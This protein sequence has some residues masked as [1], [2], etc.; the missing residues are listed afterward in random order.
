MQAKAVVNALVQNASE[1]SVTLQNQDVFYTAV[2]GGNRGGKARRA[3]S[4]DNQ[5]IFH[6]VRYSFL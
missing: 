6:H 3:S 2:E 5:I 1:F 4:Y